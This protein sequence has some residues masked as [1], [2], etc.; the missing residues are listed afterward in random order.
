MVYVRFRMR[1]V[2]C[3]I[4]WNRRNGRLIGAV[5][6]LLP[7]LAAQ[8]AWLPLGGLG[9]MTRDVAVW[10]QCGQDLCRCLPEPVCALCAHDEVVACQTAVASV[11]PRKTDSS[12]ARDLQVR[13]ASLLSGLVA[14]PDAD[15]NRWVAA[16]AERPAVDA[17]VETVRP[18]SRSLRPPTPP[19][20]A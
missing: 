6:M 18:R 14:I 17:A 20:W 19:P 7:F 9:G 16:D 5:V 11:A 2:G 15:S 10:S 13:L 12:P 3:V 1:P 4:A 8:L